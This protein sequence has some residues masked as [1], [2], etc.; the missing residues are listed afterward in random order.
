[1]KF[2]LIV[3]NPPYN[4]NLHLKILE[5]V[6]PLSDKVIWL[7]PARWLQD[8]LAKYKKNSDI[9][10]FSKILKALQ[11][12]DIQDSALLS[13]AFNAGLAFDMAI[14]TLSEDKATKSFIA[15]NNI[16]DK[17]YDKM[18]GIPTTIVSKVTSD[19][20]VLLT[21]LDSGHK[22]RGRQHGTDSFQ[23]V[24]NEKWYGS[25]YKNNV[26]SNGF[27]LLENKQRNKRSTNGNIET[28]TC[29][30]FDSETETINFVASTK[31]CFFRYLY[32]IEMVGM[33][34]FPSFLPYMGDYTQ[35]W[36]NERFYEYFEL[37]PEEI[38]EIETTMAPYMEEK[39]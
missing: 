20:F 10:R 25:Y 33:D 15:S 14:Y 27:T 38:E 32:M 30:Q 29:T 2:D 22:E 17:V 5:K 37:T 16:L 8:P 24:R 1:M 31:T 35:P 21:T 9:F 23:L 3:G 13:K 6:I 26:S 7:A 18:C 19:Y 39:K 36:T 28:W 34:I 11:D 12:V 4:R